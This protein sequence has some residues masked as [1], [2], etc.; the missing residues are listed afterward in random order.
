VQRN[1]ATRDRNW[2]QQKKK[3][4]TAKRGREEEGTR[5]REKREL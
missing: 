2:M 5:E 4:F 1:A 3:L